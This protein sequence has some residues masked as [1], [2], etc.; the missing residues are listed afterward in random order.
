MAASKDL[1]STSGIHEYRKTDPRIDDCVQLWR[2]HLFAIIDDAVGIFFNVRKC[3][4]LEK[5]YLEQLKIHENRNIKY[6]ARPVSQDTIKARH[7]IER[8][9]FLDVL[10]FA[11]YP[12]T[13]YN[14]LFNF[15][16]QAISYEKKIYEANRLD[17]R[18]I[19]LI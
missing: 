14:Q 13:F 1:D 9:S 10:N 16:Q 5:Q 8:E 12:D 11:G 19:N 2:A 17:T 18:Q 15:V 7:K 6:I 3:Q 4:D